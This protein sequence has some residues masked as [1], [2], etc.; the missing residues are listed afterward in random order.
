MCR[1]RCCCS[2][3]RS[4]AVNRLIQNSIQGRLIAFALA[5]VVGAGSLWA[6]PA[7]TVTVDAGAPRTPVSPSLYGIFFE[8]INHAGEGGLYAEMV[9]NRDFEMT[10][11]PKGAVWAGNLLRA[12]A[13][14]QERKWFG[15]EL[16]GWKVLAEG[17]GEGAPPGPEYDAPFAEEP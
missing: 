2:D 11:L 4:L 13:K 12:E 16:W 7:V 8:E 17:G 14:W 15:N 10:T 3:S 6:E 1:A 9:L 5:G